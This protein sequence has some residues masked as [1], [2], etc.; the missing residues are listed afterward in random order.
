MGGRLPSGRL[1]DPGAASAGVSSCFPGGPGSGV[2]AAGTGS[3]ASLTIEGGPG[4]LPLGV[5]Q[6]GGTAAGAVAGL[7]LAAFVG[8]FTVT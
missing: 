2:S 1:L 4:M 5:P 6:G 3:G 8:S 7:G